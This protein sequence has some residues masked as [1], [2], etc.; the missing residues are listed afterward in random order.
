M[1]PPWRADHT[2]V[3]QVCFSCL[4]C[5][6]SNCP[7]TTGHYSLFTRSRRHLMRRGG[8]F[9]VIPGVPDKRQG[10]RRNPESLP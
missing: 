3:K 10:S 5:R 6:F 2:R 1:P 9:R 7:L 8:R 4:T